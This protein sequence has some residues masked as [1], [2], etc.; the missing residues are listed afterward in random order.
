MGH[1]RPPEQHAVDEHAVGVEL[2]AP[3]LGGLPDEAKGVT[4]VGATLTPQGTRCHGRACGRRE[5]CPHLKY[6][7]LVHKK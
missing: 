6:N 4:W 7:L 1:V 2:S 5:S 3:V